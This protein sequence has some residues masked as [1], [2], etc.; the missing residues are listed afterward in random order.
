MQGDLRKEPA[1]MHRR[2]VLVLL[3][4]AG[5]RVCG[6]PPVIH[7]LP[8]AEQVLSDMHLS[9]GDR[10]RV[11]GGEFVTADVPAVS[12][13][14][15]SFAIAFLVKTAPD[16]L[17]KQVMSGNLVTA[18]AQVQTWGE[19]KGGGSLAEFA[20][21]KITSDEARALSAA[22]AGDAFNL[23]TAEIAAFSG[24][25]GGPEAVL[26]QLQKMLLA[27][28]QAYRTSGL[29][30]IAAYDRGGGR[31]TDHAAD[32]RKASEAT[33]GLKKYLSA[34]Q[35]VLLGYPKATAP[36]M[37]ES[38]F[39]VKSIIEGKATYI[40]THLL[41]APDG[42]AYA[43]VRRQYYASTN[44]NGEQSVAGFL[45]VPDGTVVVLASHAFTDQV[46]GFGGSMKR[47]IGSSVMARKMREIFE[48]GRKKVAS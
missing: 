20:R 48:A 35:A 8:S 3:A 34:V 25:T 16:A 2:R 12:D 9:A 32:L 13:R 24:A 33:A 21:L 31:T 17:G 4:A 30:G 42:D 23:S 38:F 26:Q 39:W 44:Y 10:Q 15:L 18:D 46:T 36:Q 37:R 7:A 40:L 28:H 27:R 43:L 5:A 22:K 1:M 19:L 41:A 45:P 29:A 6:A 47:S 11:L 14:D